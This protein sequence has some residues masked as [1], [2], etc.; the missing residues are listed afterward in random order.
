ME[1]DAAVVA[2]KNYKTVLE[3][4]RVRALKISYEAFEKGPMHSHPDGVF[5]G[6]M[7]MNGTFTYPDGSSDDI[8]TPAGMAAYFP[9][10]THQAEGKIAHRFEGYFIELKDPVDGSAL[11]S[12][13]S[14]AP[15]E[16]APGTG[17]GWNDSARVALDPVVVAGKQYQVVTDN[18][19][20][21]VLR[22]LYGP[23]EHGTMHAHPDSVLATLTEMNGTFR[24]PDGKAEEV[25]VPAGEVMYLPA[26]THAPENKTPNRFEGFLVE[27]K[28]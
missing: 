21:R 3:N 1:L 9:A 11:D 17:T 27:L 7:E 16:G 25:V 5:V 18:D 8:W 13:A 28:R 10:V 2:S 24:Y 23:F 15:K 4:D 20:V 14:P 26:T 19:R 6:L 22:I 12:H